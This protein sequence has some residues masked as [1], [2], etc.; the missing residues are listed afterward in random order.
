[1]KRLFVFL[2]LLLLLWACSSSDSDTAGA[3]SETTNGIALRVADVNRQP[4][5]RARVSLYSKANLLKLDSAIANED[6]IAYIQSP[7][8]ECYLEGIADND[9]SLMVWDDYEAS[10]E[11]IVLLPAA[12][13]IIR[14][15]NLNSGEELMS[16]AGTPYSAQWVEGAYVF[17]H[18]PAGEFV[19]MHGDDSVMQVS[20]EAGDTVNIAVSTIVDDSDSSK[21]DSDSSTVESDSVITEPEVPTAESDTIVL[22]SAGIFVFEDF[23]DGDSLNN[24]AKYYRNHGWY[25]T[26]LGDA[27]WVRPG[28]GEPFSA[29]LDSS[30]TRGKFLSSKFDVG[31]SGMVILGSHLGTDSMYF[32]MSGLTAIRIV[33]RSDSDFSVALEHYAAVA[34]NTFN[35]AMWKVSSSTEWT[36]VVLKPGEEIVDAKINQVEWA[37]VSREIALFSI[38]SSTGSFIEIDKVVFEGV[39]FVYYTP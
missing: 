13:L 19:V 9:S 27:R 8:E 33:Y 18:V 37:E 3:T 25:F 39:N 10:D 34:E 22:D 29:V 26:M 6:G 28:T 32:D 5:A 20:F 4:V 1:M 36:E 24:L 38:F 7:A 21:I 15:D 35:K 23:E 16:L 2:T 31:D 30:E 17:A 12:S 11:E 14:D